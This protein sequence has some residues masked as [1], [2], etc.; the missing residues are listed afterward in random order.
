VKAAS[1]ESG[2]R[3]VQVTDLD[4]SA[5]SSVELLD[6]EA[7]VYISLTA[8]GNGAVMLRGQVAAAAPIPDDGLAALGPGIPLTLE[9]A[10]GELEV[11]FE[12]AGE[13]IRF[14]GPLVGER[15]VWPARAQGQLSEHGNTK[16]ISGSGVIH[17]ASRLP[18]SGSLRRDVTVMLD[19]GGLLCIATAGRQ[20]S[21]DHGE[22]DG[23]AALSHPGGHFDFERVLLSTETDAAGRQRRATIEL[24][25]D[26]EDV[27]VLHG[28]GRSHC[29]CTAR[30]PG[31]S[32]NTALF[33][34][35]VD[36]HTGTGRYELTR[37][38][39]DTSA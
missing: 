38:N 25:P 28:A 31:G 21:H 8:G 11:S 17:T 30:L 2:E 20:G 23:V 9:T 24:K 22:E 5:I 6:R 1:D 32:V 18:A 33:D 34:W 29:G 3:S 13:P 36:G 26:R 19:D 27:A 10:Q 39:P 7:G 15:I 35:Q 16:A 37:P 12:P 14:D 4:G